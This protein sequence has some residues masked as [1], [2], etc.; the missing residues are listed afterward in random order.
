MVYVPGIEKN[1]HFIIKSDLVFS[2]NLLVDR[3]MQF[4]R[5][6]VWDSVGKQ[7]KNAFYLDFNMI[8]IFCNGLD[9]L[10]MLN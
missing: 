6:I 8:Y 4:T 10:N 9:C 1:E 2:K 5:R 3:R 7:L